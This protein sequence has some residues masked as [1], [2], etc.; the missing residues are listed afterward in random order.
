MTSLE[1]IAKTV[2]QTATFYFSALDRIWLQVLVGAKHS[3][4]N[5]NW[6]LATL[7][8]EASC[9]VDNFAGVIT[10]VIVEETF[11]LLFTLVQALLQRKD[12]TSVTCSKDTTFSVTLQYLWL[13]LKIS[14]PF[15]NVVVKCTDHETP[16]STIIALLIVYVQDWLSRASIL[17]LLLVVIRHTLGDIYRS[18]CFRRSWASSFLAMAAELKVRSK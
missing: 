9:D 4:E 7:K 6:G 12:S 5:I 8:H 1:L 10:Y 16:V 15:S 2:L 17:G 3:Q 14:R 13:N 11:E 18:K